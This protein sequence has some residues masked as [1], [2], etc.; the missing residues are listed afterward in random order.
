M[1]RRRR[2]GTWGRV[3]VNLIGVCKFIRLSSDVSNREHLG[4]EGYILNDRSGGR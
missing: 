1:M 2:P 4:N 3:I